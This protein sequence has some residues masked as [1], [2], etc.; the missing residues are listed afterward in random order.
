MLLLPI[1]KALPSS[2]SATTFMR[3]F[4]ILDLIYLD[5]CQSHLITADGRITLPGIIR[6]GVQSLLDTQTP[7]MGF[8]GL[9]FRGHRNY[10]IMRP[11]KTKALVTN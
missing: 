8:A 9:V 3:Q 2:T 5:S 4:H 7:T 1:I 6:V 11:K 10:T